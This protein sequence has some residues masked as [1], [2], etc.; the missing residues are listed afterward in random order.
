MV[1]RRSISDQPHGN[2]LCVCAWG[3]LS[4]DLGPQKAGAWAV[5]K[6]VNP[7]SVLNHLHLPLSPCQS[8]LHGEHLNHLLS[9]REVHILTKTIAESL[10]RRFSALG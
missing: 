1:S 5:G 8:P 10:L 3:N 9:L 7:K 2:C 6:A 4:Q